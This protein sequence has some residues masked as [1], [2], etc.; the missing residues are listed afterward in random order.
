MHHFLFPIKDS[1]ISNRDDLLLKNFGV[2]EILQVGV[3]D[4]TTKITKQTKTY[5][6]NNTSV[7]TLFSNFTGLVTGSFSS[8]I[9]NTFSGSLSGSNVL[10]TASYVSGSV[11]AAY[12][13]GYETGSLRTGSFNSTFLSFSGSISSST[14]NVTVTSSLKLDSF[15]AIIIKGTLTNFN[16]SFSGS[17]SGSD[18]VSQQNVT[19]LNKKFI[20]R[21][22]LKF[23]ISSISSSISSGD[24]QNPKF[25]LNLKVAKEENLPVIYKI[26]AFPVSQSWEI[27]D[28]YFFDGGSN[29]G[30]SWNYR[31]YNGGAFWYPI[32]ASTTVVDYL[33][34][35]SLATASFTN[36]GGTWYTSAS[37]MGTQ[38][39][40]HQ[41]SDIKMD[42]TS[43]VMAWVSGSI[44]NEGII[45]IN[46]QE[47]DTSFPSHA[48]LKYFSRDTNSIYSPFLDVKWD[49]STFSTGSITTGSV[50]TYVASG[51]ISSSF[52]TGSILDT[53]ANLSGSVLSGS[54][55]GSFI[56]ATILSGS[57]KTDIGNVEGIY[58]GSLF[59][60]IFVNGSFRG[61]LVSGSLSGSYVT[62]SVGTL[63][64]LD[65]SSLEPLQLS[66]PFTIVVKNLN[67]QYKFGD[68]VRINLFG[69]V[70]FP[71]KNFTRKTQLSDF[72]TPKYLPSSSY[73]SIKDNETEEILVDFDNYSKVSCDGSGNYFILDT[74]GLPS[75]RFFKVLAKVEQ[76]GSVFTIDNNDVFKIS[77]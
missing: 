8:T 49:N 40:D 60:G 42:V 73:Y 35:A 58:S 65:S 41:T 36:G 37:Y 76:S 21:A 74:T 32:T 11:N 55:S 15:G 69:R 25:D 48:K 12:V 27:G 39:F 9:F 71:L 47:I 30:V 29:L 4:Q 38:S 43:M 28:G 20:D 68:I 50:V 64:I 70:Q 6:Y 24:I 44:P 66:T 72:L 52:L 19:I 77:R 7:L 62:S 75:E 1:F 3:D 10:F 2:D 59:R 67:D 26:H 63:T 18:I 54:A 13:N 45:L 17:V 14:V 53:G 46:S 34:T 23:D 16:G 57:S 5:N 61:D 56:V 33:N 31:D 51:S 22:L